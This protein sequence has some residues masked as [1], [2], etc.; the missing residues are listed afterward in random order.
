MPHTSDSVHNPAGPVY[1]I[2]IVGR[3]RK[4]T[5]EMRLAIRPGAGEEPE[6]FFDLRW[7]IRYRAGVTRPSI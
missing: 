1:D 7:I 2:L 6:G 5:F 4:I 3:G